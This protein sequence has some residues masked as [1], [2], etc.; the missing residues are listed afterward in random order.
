MH[1]INSLEEEFLEI[2]DFN[3]SIDRQ[4]YDNYVSGLKGFF[5]NPL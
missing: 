2:I 3:L 5:T 4:E 1:E